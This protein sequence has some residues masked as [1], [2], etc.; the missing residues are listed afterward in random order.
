MTAGR[1][2]TYKE[3]YNQKVDDYLALNQD[4]E[5]EVVSMRNDEKGYEKFDT[6]L[7]VRL[8]TIE[9]FALFINTPKRTIYEWKDKFEEF[10]HSLDKIVTEQQNRLIN[11]GL[12]G[13]YNPT[14]AKLILSANH[15]MRERTDITS[16]DKVLPILGGL[17]KENDNLQEHNSNREDLPTEKEN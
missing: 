3:E 8:P 10:S 1:P 14:I 7:K 15:G 2:T 6:K 4:E 17:S 9:G 5:I 12:S 11:M 16:D 13:Q